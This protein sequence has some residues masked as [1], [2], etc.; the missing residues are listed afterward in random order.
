MITRF[1]QPERENRIVI[2]YINKVHLLIQ[3]CV[4]L[5]VLR[6]LRVSN[7]AFSKDLNVNVFYLK[8]ICRI[9]SFDL[10]MNL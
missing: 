7:F 3:N 1:D 5:V 6:V 9:H 8:I 10:K 2:L 4:N